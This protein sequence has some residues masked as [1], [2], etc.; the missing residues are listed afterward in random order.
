[1]TGVHIRKQPYE[2]RGKQG[3]RVKWSVHSLTFHN[4]RNHHVIAPALVFYLHNPSLMCD[5]VTSPGSLCPYS[6]PAPRC[7]PDLSHGPRFAVP[8]PQ[9]TNEI[10][11]IAHLGLSD[12][13]RVSAEAR[14]DAGRLCS[15]LAVP[16]EVLKNN[17]GIILL[18]RIGV[19]KNDCS[20]CNLLASRGRLPRE[21]R[22]G[23]R[24]TENHSTRS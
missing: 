13:M 1:M 16:W 2:A 14:Q 5:R 12:R 8:K 6:E 18:L 3:S 19:E 9:I 20:E 24:G 21:G 4:S 11:S 15:P 22:G 17:E 7:R 10:G 23:T